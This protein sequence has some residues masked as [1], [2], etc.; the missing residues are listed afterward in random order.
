[1]LPGHGLLPAAPVSS[2][3]ASSERAPMTPSSQTPAASDSSKGASSVSWGLK[4]AVWVMALILAMGFGVVIATLVYRI[5]AA[6]E[7]PP[8]AAPL[9]YSA[10]AGSDLQSVQ[11]AETG[12]VLV[13]RLAEGG[14]LIVFA[15][16]SQDP[17]TWPT[18]RTRPAQ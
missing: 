15:D 14:H 3:M 8:G 12:A 11:A 6:T 18:L 9:V 7:R 10:P 2:T 16:P 5:S 17:D 1:M 4:A 13:Y